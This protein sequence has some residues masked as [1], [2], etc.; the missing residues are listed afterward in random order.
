M[1]KYDKIENRPKITF[2]KGMILLVFIFL[3]AGTIVL[4]TNAANKNT[5]VTKSGKTYYYNANGEKATGLKK[6]KGRYYHFD[7]KGILYK[8][9]W[10]TIKSNK[11]Y[12]DKKTGAA[13]RG[14]KKI[15]GRTYYFNSKG[16]MQAGKWKTISGKKYYFDANGRSTN[17]EFKFYAHRGYRGKYPE[18][19]V[20]AFKGAMN[21]GFDGIEFDIF[22]TKSG[23]IFVFHDE[24]TDRMCKISDCIY[25]V[26]AKNRK[27]YPIVTGKNID[28]YG[29]LL[30]P[31]FEETI[32]AMKNKKADLFIHLKGLDTISEQ[33][34]AK[35]DKILRKYDM[36]DKSIIFCGRTSLLKKFAK[37]GLHIGVN[38][39]STSTKT[40]MTHVEE[41]IEANIKTFIVFYPNKVNQKLVNKCHENGIRIGV[42][43]VTE[44]S[45]AIRLNKLGVDFVFTDFKLW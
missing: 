3:C 28:R 10:K 39:T 8:K 45:E 17:N 37:R 15:N 33:G 21:A 19:T 4:N 34:I 24:T 31:S 11:Y 6:L 5:W 29:S 12:F 2:R 7:K 36:V 35:I 13:A 32:A 38:M 30:I 40:T 25:N 14:L 26:N 23:D 22:E 44:K 9:G 16:K 42:Y 18:N 43:K 1:T 20:V 41:C 27:Q